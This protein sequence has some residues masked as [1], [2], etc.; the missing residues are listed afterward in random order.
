MN[1]YDAK[2]K[3]DFKASK[4]S[5]YFWLLAA[6]YNYY[7]AQDSTPLLSDEL[8]DKACKWLLE[9]YDS[10]QHSKLVHLVDKESLQAGS[11]YHILDNQYPQ[12]LV[13]MAQ[14]L[15]RKLDNV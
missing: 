12:W 5:C 11:F 10:V 15:T 8:F 1:N 6:S 9:N 4:K 7:I 3:Q 2:F 14:E 13:R